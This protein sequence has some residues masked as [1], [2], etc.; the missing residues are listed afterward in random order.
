MHL[1]TNSGPK[2]GKQG[3]SSFPRK[4]MYLT[5]NETPRQF[6][7]AVFKTIRKTDQQQEQKTKWWWGSRNNIFIFFFFFPTFCFYNKF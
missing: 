6:Q 7:A 1:Y 4:I 5:E 2:H 3:Y